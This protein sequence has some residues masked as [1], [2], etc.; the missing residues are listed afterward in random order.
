MSEGRY[1]RLPKPKDRSKGVSVKMGE[2]SLTPEHD[3]AGEW[4][5]EGDTYHAHAK[6]PRV[7][8]ES[9]LAKLGRMAGEL[10]ASAGRPWSKMMGDDDEGK[11]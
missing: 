11:E 4:E 8:E 2:V 7:A 10:G 9:M 1:G 3:K 5:E 6:K